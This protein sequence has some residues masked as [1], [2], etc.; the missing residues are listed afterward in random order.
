MAAIP[1][2][3]SRCCGGGLAFAGRKM[4]FPPGRLGLIAIGTIWL[5]SAVLFLFPDLLTAS[6]YNIDSYYG[7]VACPF[8]I[9]WAML[10]WRK[11]RAAATHA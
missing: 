11:S 9:A 2:V 5:W 1:T 8:A 3:L 7:L 10:A 6:P 4:A